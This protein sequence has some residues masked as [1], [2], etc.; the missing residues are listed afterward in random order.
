MGKKTSKTTPRYRDA[1]TGHLLSEA[2]AKKL[3]K[4]QVVQE[5]LPKPGHGVK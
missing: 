3:P 1:G 5:R 4:N 2:Q